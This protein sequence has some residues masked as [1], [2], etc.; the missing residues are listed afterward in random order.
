MKRVA[1]PLLQH[2]GSHVSHMGKPKTEEECKLDEQETT[3]SAISDSSDC[4]KIFL[5]Q[6]LAGQESARGAGL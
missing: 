4:G 5:Q 6:H 1:G 2:Q 3:L